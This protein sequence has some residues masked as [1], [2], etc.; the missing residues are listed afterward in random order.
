[1]ERWD[2]ITPPPEKPLELPREWRSFASEEK[3]GSKTNQKV[4]IW[5]QIDEGVDC[6]EYLQ[7]TH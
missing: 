6:E 4:D 3:E 5:N 2:S 1:M 7:T